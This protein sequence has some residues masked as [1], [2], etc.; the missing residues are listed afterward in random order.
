VSSDGKISRRGFF[1]LFGRRDR[2]EAP[3]GG[4]SI[5]DL[6]RQRAAQGQDRAE[7]PAIRLRPGLDRLGVDTTD[8]GVPELGSRPRRRRR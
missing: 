4:F 1:A 8:V 7:L 3:R 6:Y 2:S 5:T